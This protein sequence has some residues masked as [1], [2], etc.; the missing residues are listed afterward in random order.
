MLHSVSPH[1]WSPCLVYSCTRH[2]PK[3]SKC[4]VYSRLQVRNALL[5]GQNNG[6]LTYFF[7]SRSALRSFQHISVIP[8][9]ITTCGRGVLQHPPGSTIWRWTTI[10]QERA[11]R[12][13]NVFICA[14]VVLLYCIIL[15]DTTVE[16][17]DL[18]TTKSSI[19]CTRAS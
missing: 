3:K 5:V 13:C 16:I 9:R 6:S 11:T 8:S 4:R 2:S 1:A 18:R 10:I 7:R 12:D 15:N 19:E 14:T 17:Q